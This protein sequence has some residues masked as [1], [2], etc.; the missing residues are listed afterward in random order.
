MNRT[1]LSLTALSLLGACAP[2]PL[3]MRIERFLPIDQAT[4]FS[5]DDPKLGLAAGTL[6]VSPGGTPEYLVGFR[7]IGGDAFIQP[8]YVLTGGRQLEAE[9]RNQPIL[10]RIVLSYAAR[11]A[12]GLRLG[13]VQVSRSMP[14][15]EGELI[16][17][18]NVISPDLAQDLVTAV[19]PGTDVE[20]TVSVEARGYM[21]GDRAQI[22]TGKLEFPL[23][24]T[25]TDPASCTG[26]VI[27]PT[28][29][30]CLYPGQDPVSVCCDQLTGPPPG[31][32]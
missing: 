18:V 26:G 23:K 24:V 13:S 15:N 6:D 17:T 28:P 30:T 19:V 3:P 31:C 10:D 27:Q 5:T 21:S 20:L 12:G 4:C 2:N 29:G 7:V 14:L 16:S 32:P 1:L 8:P 22:T 11:P 25:A 9:N